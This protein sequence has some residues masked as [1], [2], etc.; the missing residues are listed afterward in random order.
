MCL[1]RFLLQLIPKVCKNLFKHTVFQAGAIMEPGDIMDTDV[2][3]EGC[4]LEDVHVNPIEE[5]KLPW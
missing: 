4:R 1:K 3:L 5:I 2:R